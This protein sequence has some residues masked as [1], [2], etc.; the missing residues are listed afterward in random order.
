VRPRPF[1]IVPLLMALRLDPVRLLIAD[2]V[3]IGKTIEVAL[4]AR[5]LLD[6]GEARRLAV[7]CP[8]HLCEHPRDP[9]MGIR[10]KRPDDWERIARYVGDRWRGAIDPDDPGRQVS[11]NTFVDAVWEIRHT[12]NQA[13]HTDPVP[14][15]AYSR[16]FRNVCQGGQVR[17]GALNAL[18]LAW[19]A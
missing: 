3:G 7:I 5:E 18:L 12:R 14:R 19:P 8:P 2:D 17:I 1:Q 11:F 15:E 16:L 6:R 9:D 10:R 13:A 4:V